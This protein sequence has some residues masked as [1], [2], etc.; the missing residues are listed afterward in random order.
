MILY[1]SFL[2]FLR[3]VDDFR[4]GWSA[5]VSVV[6]PY[7]KHVDHA[8]GRTA[9]SAVGGPTQSGRRDIKTRGRP[10]G[11]GRR[12]DCA[13]ARSA[14]APTAVR[15]AGCR[16]HGVGQGHGHRSRQA[17]IRHRCCRRRRRRLAS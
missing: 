13:G 4:C 1:Y 9:R 8:A 10:D 7:T 15:G 12:R 14:E 6:F 2:I 5:R 11:R 17:V 16:G 3:A